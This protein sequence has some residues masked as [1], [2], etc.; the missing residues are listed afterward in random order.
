MVFLLRGISWPYFKR[1]W[2][3]SALTASGVALGV[4]VYIAIELSAASLKVSM[5]QTVD[6]VAGKTQ[7]EV[8]AGEA[9]FPEAA[10]EM[11]RA[12]PGVAA[13]QPVVEAVV[14]AEGEAESRRFST[15]RS[16]SWLNQTRSA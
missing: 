14:R 2:V 8:T 5:R 11:V 4:G 1:H 10:L 16:S 6:R 9:G 12:T 3:I 15:I 7:L 13:A